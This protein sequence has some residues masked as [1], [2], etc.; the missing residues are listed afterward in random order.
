ML[1]RKLLGK[2]EQDECLHH[3]VNC[4]YCCDVG[5]YT[6]ITGQ[7]KD[8][9]PKFP[10]PCPNSDCNVVVVRKD[11][12]EYRKT[13]RYEMVD[14][15]NGYGLAFQQRQLHSHTVK[16]FHT[17]QSLVSIAVSQ[18]SICLFRENTENSVQNYPYLVQTSVI[19][20]SL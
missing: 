18:E 16:I 17:K 3:K 13:C 9:C 20:I 1:Q 4:K 2:H 8:L 7:H 12:D 11:V 19:L 6:F 5:A 14:C 10:M 15:C